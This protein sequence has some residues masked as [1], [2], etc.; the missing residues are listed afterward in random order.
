[1]KKRIFM[2][3]SIL[4]LTLFLLAGVCRPES[5]TIDKSDK[6]ISLKGP[7]LIDR[8]QGRSFNLQ[9]IYGTVDL[10]Q[11]EVFNAAPSVL[12]ES[13]PSYTSFTEGFIPCEKNELL[14]NMINVY[15]NLNNLEPITYYYN[16]IETAAY[17]FV[18]LS[19]G[20][21]SVYII[22]HE[23][24]EVS[25]PIYDVPFAS[26]K[27]YVYHITEGDDAFYI[28]SAK[29]NSYEAFWYRLDKNNFNVTAAKRLMPPLTAYTK[30]QYALDSTGTSYF[31]GN[32]NLYVVSDDETYS[33]P[34]GFTPDELH[35]HENLLYA[36]SVSELFLNYAIFDEDLQSIMTGYVNLPNK[37][38]RLV[39]SLLEQQVLYTIT[40]DDHHP[41]YRNYLTLYDL[42]KGEMIYCIALKENH[43]LALLDIEIDSLKK[44]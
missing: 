11:I 12:I 15:R 7:V 32:T 31:A 38:V 41:V 34:L 18:S 8:L 36:F 5:S 20:L 21:G 6:P 13:S 1:M 39:D 29:A 42:N 30:N 43:N 37:E 4:C 17:D 24:G 16:Y 44:E 40:Y 14:L 28:L 9:L 23:T 10:G 27:Q 35:Y 2:V 22:N 33:I 25:T 26:E 3:S 19:D